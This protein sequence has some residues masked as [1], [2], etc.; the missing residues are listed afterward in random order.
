MRNAMIHR[1]I[2]LSGHDFAALGDIFIV[3][4]E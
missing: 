4:M 1:E 3:G 2:L